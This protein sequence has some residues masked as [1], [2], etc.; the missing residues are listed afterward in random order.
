MGERALRETLDSILEETKNY[1]ESTV[2]LY[3]HAYP[4]NSKKVLKQVK[5]A[6]S[7]I[8]LTVPNNKLSGLVNDYCNTLY[9]RFKRL[10]TSKRLKNIS[11]KVIGSPDNFRVDCTFISKDLETNIFKR[12]NE[13]RTGTTGKPPMP[14]KD[15]QLK[16]PKLYNKLVNLRDTSPLKILRQSI[17]LELYEIE[18]EG[19]DIEQDSKT[20]DVILGYKQYSKEDNAFMG[21]SGGLLHLGHLDG[22]AVVERRAQEIVRRLKETVPNITVGK[23]ILSKTLRNRDKTKSKISLG[24]T[25]GY[26]DLELEVDYTAVADEFAGL[27]ISKE[28]EQKLI[29]N[30]S[31]SFLR[32]KNWSKVEGSESNEDALL[33]D[34][35]ASISD[36]IEFAFS[37]VKGAKL[38]SRKNTER[39]R[40][41][42]S[43]KQDIKI[44]LV[45]N[46][47][48]GS[49]DNFPSSVKS[50]KQKKELPEQNWSSLL[51]LIN[52]KLTPRVIANMRSPSLVNR[53][54]RFAQSAEVVRIEET[55][56]GSP[57]FVFNYERDPYDV[58]DRTLGRAPWNT[59]ER[60]PRALV[61]KSVREIVREMAI[62]RFY[63]RRA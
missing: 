29:S 53:T 44:N 10:E 43:V 56:E 31:K 35:A 3:S 11:Y 37:K 18:L 1:R 14:N 45:K 51:P 39:K 15:I 59:P 8:G 62:G 5:L 32:K 13:V 25:L 41:P 33:N 49:G 24:G 26:I 63:T 30:I 42:T 61:D 60:D 38:V 52:S 28:Y 27:N 9:D 36:N 2:D 57:S 48:E 17:L 12:I 47:S 23:A 34:A 22:F 21:R 16:D 20:L 58:F 7:E 46:K 4:V 19:L 54:G 50:A 55:R 40:K 6:V